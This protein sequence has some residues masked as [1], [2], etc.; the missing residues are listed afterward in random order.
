MQLGLDGLADFRKVDAKEDKRWSNWRSWPHFSMAWDQGPDNV[1]VFHWL[2]S[3]AFN[4]TAIWD[5]QHG[6]HNDFKGM[7]ADTSNTNCGCLMLVVWNCL[8]GPKQELRSL[9]WN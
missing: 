1:C 4:I 3:I 8:S 7:L 9:V 5:W 6:T 2:L